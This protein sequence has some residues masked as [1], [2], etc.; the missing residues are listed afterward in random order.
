M[1]IRLK[2]MQLIFLIFGYD[3]F[4][5]LDFFKIC[6]FKFKIF[7]HEVIFFTKVD[8]NNQFSKK[9]SINFC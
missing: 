2:D 8:L 6:F 9:R 7:Y 4:S 1:I 5:A 3:R